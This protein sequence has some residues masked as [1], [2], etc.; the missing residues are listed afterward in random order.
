MSLGEVWT[1]TM[2]LKHLNN[3]Y[4]CN[5]LLFGK[6]ILHFFNQINIAVLQI[7]FKFSPRRW[8]VDEPLVAFPHYVQFITIL[9]TEYTH[10]L[11]VSNNVS[12]M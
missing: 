9:L 2:D 12:E 10:P 1:P 3:T 4:N 7:S 8:N 5:A 11:T 6:I